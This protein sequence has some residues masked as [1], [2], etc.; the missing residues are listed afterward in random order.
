M[1]IVKKEQVFPINNHMMA[2]EAS[3]IALA[4]G[5]WPEFIGVLDDQNTGFLFQ[6]M[7][8]NE[9]MGRYQTS[10]GAFELHVLND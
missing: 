3:E 9:E 5:E 8:V 4:P 2:C 7:L 10:D 6:K 1:F